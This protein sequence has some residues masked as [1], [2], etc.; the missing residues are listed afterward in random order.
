MEFLLC[1][2]LVSADRA[3]K[4]FDVKTGKL[5]YTLGEATDWLYTVAWSPDGKY[6][7]SGGVDK[8]IRVYE[9][10][11]SAAKLRQ[12]VFAH[13]GPVQKLVFLQRFEDA[14]FRRPRSRH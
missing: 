2:D 7:V 12:S 10:T 4:V 3:M 1:A 5:L 13:E 14:L 11:P 8:S 9:P 6:L